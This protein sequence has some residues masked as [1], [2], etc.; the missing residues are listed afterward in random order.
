MYFDIYMT[1]VI[2]ARSRL[3]TDYQEILC[4]AAD[5]SEDGFWAEGTEQSSRLLK[6]ADESNVHDE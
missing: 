4:E 3:Y 2:P 6:K 5:K 1:S